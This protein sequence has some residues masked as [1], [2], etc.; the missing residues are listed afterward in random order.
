M[1]FFNH[2]IYI[3]YN[4]RVYLLQELFFNNFFNSLTMSNVKIVF[5]ICKLCKYLFIKLL[6]IIEFIGMYDTIYT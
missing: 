5:Y 1:L 6:S 3:Q 4:I 2:Y